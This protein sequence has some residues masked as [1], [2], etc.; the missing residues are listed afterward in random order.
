MKNKIN[1]PYD[2]VC[3]KVQKKLRYFLLFSVNLTEENQI[4]YEYQDVEERK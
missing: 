2:D 4:L 1:F 3:R